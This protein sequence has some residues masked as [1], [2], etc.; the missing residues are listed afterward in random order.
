M[1]LVQPRRVALL[2]LV[3]LWLTTCAW[4]VAH[5]ADLQAA[6]LDTGS[7]TNSRKVNNNNKLAA[8][9]YNI[10]G[11]D[12]STERAPL[13]L[14]AT[15]EA[16]GGAVATL[17]MQMGALAEVD[18]NASE[19]FLRGFNWAPGAAG[20]RRDVAR[21]EKAVLT[22]TALDGDA[23]LLG[24]GLD[25]A[26]S[27]ERVDRDSNFR[28]RA[29]PILWR[30][31]PTAARARRTAIGSFTRP[32]VPRWRPSGVC[33][34][35]DG[36]RTRRACRVRVRLPRSGWRTRAKAYYRFF[37]DTRFDAHFWRW[38]WLAQEL[39]A[40]AQCAIARSASSPSTST[41]LRRDPRAVATR[42]RATAA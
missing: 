11:D 7:T 33:S 10:I 22:A 3:A 32:A 25:A 17:L 4:L 9:V 27:I 23:W 28:R 29:D 19:L 41:S 40:L 37:H 1:W 5:T 13:W 38:S 42:A 26:S 34:A 15:P 6:L 31:W 16:S 21:A 35:V 20:E 14:L 24:L 2:A 18:S 8:H 39:S 12:S 30:A 36:S